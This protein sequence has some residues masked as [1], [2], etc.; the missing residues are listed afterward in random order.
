MQA[1]AAPH[2][3]QQQ[4]QPQ[5]FKPKTAQDLDAEMEQYRRQGHGR[6]GLL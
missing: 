4:Q 2:Q 3:Q 5:K 1:A 6:M